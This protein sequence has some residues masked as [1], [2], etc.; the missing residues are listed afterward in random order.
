LAEPTA[1]EKKKKK[2]IS[3]SSF[4]CPQEPCHVSIVFMG[5]SLTR[6]MYISLAY[7]LRHNEWIDPDSYPN[8]VKPADFPGGYALK[9]DWM[10][11]YNVSTAALAPYENC[12]CHREMGDIMR[13]P[14]KEWIC[15]NRYYYDRTRNNT[16]V[17]FQSFGNFIP[18]RGHWE[19]PQE[20]TRA[21]QLLQVVKKLA[22]ASNRSVGDEN[23]NV[24]V[25][26]LLG[27]HPYTWSYDW[28]T[29]IRHQVARIKPNVLVMNAGI[30]PHDFDKPDFVES[31]V[32]AINET[33]I[34]QTIWKTTSSD[35]NGRFERYMETDEAMCRHEFFQRDCLNITGWTS[36]LN[37]DHYIDHI[38]FREP[39]YRKMNEQLL[40]NLGISQG[41]SR[42]LNWTD[43]GI[44]DDNI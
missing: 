36:K 28:P 33:G 32:A 2:S 24:T 10:P 41:G 37:E 44:A 30:W 14:G 4:Y 39:V 21:A 23:E 3:S 5:D 43:L 20:A 26:P 15:E 22:S 8:L 29:T 9:F 19:D 1:N 40:E 7:F 11:W 18:I 16:V 17:Y 25:G 35:K 27:R 38:H 34:P 31:I 6:F 13:N 12:D 42:M